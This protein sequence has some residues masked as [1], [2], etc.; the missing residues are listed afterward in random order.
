MA[1]DLG[2]VGMVMKGDYNSASTYETLDV[3]SYNNGLYVAK[4][5]VPAGTAP[6]NTTYWQA[7]LTQ[8]VIMRERFT[9]TLVENSGATPFTHYGSFSLGSITNVISIVPDVAASGSKILVNYRSSNN[10][11]YVFGMS[12]TT[13]NVDVY[14]VNVIADT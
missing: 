5:N 1:T 6:T 9:V 13:E 14:Y 12:A 10:S 7:A 2:K 3:V 8:W 4:Q 11:V